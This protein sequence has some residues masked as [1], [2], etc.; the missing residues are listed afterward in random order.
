METGTELSKT[1]STFILQKILL[2][3]VGLHYICA[4]TERFMAVSNSLAQ[5]VTVLYEQPSTRLLKHIIRC[6]LRLSDHERAKDLLVACLPAQLA[7]PQFIACLKNDNATRRWLARLL[8]RTN[9]G[10]AAQRLCS[11]PGLQDMEPMTM[12]R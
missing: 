3:D 7:N 6:Y 2:D 11:S 9:R 1:V 4:T 5:M 12:M 8:M 10:E